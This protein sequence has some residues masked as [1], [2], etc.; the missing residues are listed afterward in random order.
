MGMTK[1]TNQKNGIS[2]AH[3]I[4]NI[5][6]ANERQGNYSDRIRRL[7]FYRL[8]APVSKGSCTRDTRSCEL[9]ERRDLLRFASCGRTCIFCD[10]S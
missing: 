9:R 10:L 2:Q 5:P 1:A 8:P 7:Y 3:R 6:Y 4:E